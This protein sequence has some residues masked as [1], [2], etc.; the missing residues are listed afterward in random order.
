MRVNSRSQEN[1]PIKE[2]VVERVNKFCYFW[3]LGEQMEMTTVNKKSP[4][5]ILSAL[6]CVAVKEISKGYQ[7]VAV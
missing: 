6:T 3:N 5:G 2:Q 4:A 1:L 7:R